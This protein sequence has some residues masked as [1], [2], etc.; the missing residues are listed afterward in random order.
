MLLAVHT[1]VIFRRFCGLCT[2]IAFFIGC[3]KPR[4]TDAH[5]SS[6]RLEVVSVTNAAGLTFSIAYA[7]LVVPQ[8]P[9]NYMLTLTADL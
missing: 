5:N 4:S 2:C 7:Y 6:S 3:D 8:L 9:R 1:A